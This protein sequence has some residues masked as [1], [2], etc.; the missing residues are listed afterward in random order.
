[1]WS[2][3]VKKHHLATLLIA[4]TSILATPAF[5]SGYGPAP[6]YRPMEGAPASQRGVSAQTVAAE[7]AARDGVN[8]AN[9]VETAHAERVQSGTTTGTGQ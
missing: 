4:A 6:H 1:M 9:V 8:K 3:T 5:A 2:I 7:Q